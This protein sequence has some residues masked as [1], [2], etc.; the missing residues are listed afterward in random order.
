[1]AIKRNL[2]ITYKQHSRYTMKMHD[3]LMENPW[4]TFKG[5]DNNTFE[6]LL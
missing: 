2:R 6:T 4:K 3:E 5:N 1:M